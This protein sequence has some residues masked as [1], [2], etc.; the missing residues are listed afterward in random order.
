M[1]LDFGPI[2]LSRDVGAL[3]TNV[4]RSKWFDPWPRLMAQ[5][6]TDLSAQLFNEPCV[7]PG[8]QTQNVLLYLNRMFDESISVCSSMP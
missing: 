3:D 2:C 5:L 4:H 8:E 6:P 7:T 1:G